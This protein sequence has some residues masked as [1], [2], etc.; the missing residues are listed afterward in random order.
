[1]SRWRPLLAVLPM[2]AGAVPHAH[3]QG[4]SSKPILPIVNWSFQV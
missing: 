3:A 4:G 1:M 2:V